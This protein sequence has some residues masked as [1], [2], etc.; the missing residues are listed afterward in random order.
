MGWCARSTYSS[1]STMGVVPLLLELG[2]DING[3]DK[4]GN[5]IPHNL[6]F[7]FHPLFNDLW[8]TSKEMI[9]FVL[10]HGGSASLQARNN[11]GHT[12][13]D[14][15]IVHLDGLT[16]RGKNRGMQIFPKFLRYRH[17][18]SEGQ[19]SRICDAMEEVSEELEGEISSRGR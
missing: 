10:E 9:D 17:L 2:A 4:K 19:I 18:L 15:L 11:K 1:N 3:V 12:P 5:T 13:V 6:I 7:W 8:E 14:L 16:F